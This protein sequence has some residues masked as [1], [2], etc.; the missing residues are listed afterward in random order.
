MGG[1][2][3]EARRRAPAFRRTTAVHRQHDAV[4]HIPPRPRS[5]GPVDARISRC[6]SAGPKGD[7]GAA[8]RSRSRDRRRSRRAA[9]GESA[10][11]PRP[12]PPT[13]PQHAC[14]PGSPDDPAS[15]RCS[16]P[17]RTTACPYRPSR[18]NRGHHRGPSSAVISP[19]S[20]LRAP[21]PLV[22]WSLYHPD[23][24][25]LSG[26][27]LTSR[28]APAGPPASCVRSLTRAYRT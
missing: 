17:A 10:T 27:R 15:S 14:I 9:C 28:P 6:R 22:P 25:R 5:N 4:E 7:P 18:P 26:L 13:S 16:S 11:L 1:P 23:D 2:R 20:A 24:R 8:G 3:P 12:S 21:K 19:F